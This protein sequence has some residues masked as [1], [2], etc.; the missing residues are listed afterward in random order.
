MQQRILY[1]RSDNHISSLTLSC[2]DFINK[3]DSSKMVSQGIV[4]GVSLLF[5]NNGSHSLTQLILDGSK[6]LV[7]TVTINIVT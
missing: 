4:R 1:N 7:W 6:D 2:D 3:D 5:D